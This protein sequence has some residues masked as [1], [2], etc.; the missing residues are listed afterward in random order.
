MHSEHPWWGLPGPARFI[1]SVRD[2]LRAGRNIVVALPEHHPAGLRGALAASL[3]DDD[4]LYFRV[5]DLS[6]EPAVAA[7]SPARFLHDRYAPIRDPRVD[8]SARTLAL[9]QPLRGTALWI[10]GMTDRLWPIWCKF[11]AEYQDACRMRREFERFLL[12]VP[13]VGPLTATLP[14]EE[15]ILAVHTWEGIVGRLDMMLHVGRRLER[16]RLDPL[17]HE[18][19]S[20]V[21]VEVCGSDLILADRLAGAPIEGIL[22]PLPLIRDEAAARGWTG[23]SP[24]DRNGSVNTMWACGMVDQLGGRPFP[25]SA[26]EV[27][28]GR[29]ETVRQR[30]WRG[31]VAVLFPFLE[32]RRLQFVRD[33]RHYLKVPVHTPYE[34]IVEFE[35]LELSHLCYQLRSRVSA[36]RLDP[37]ECCRHIRNELAHLRPLP[38]T[39]LLTPTFLALASSR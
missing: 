27:A 4:H 20:L 16:A 35:S 10:D 32:D 2:D 24:R 39:E 7:S 37:L 38:A 19:A 31:Q 28:A 9:A 26:A 15:L 36:R 21:L 12:I 3:R 25:H 13:L 17:F 22:D 30:V 5:L 34:T 6:E 29:P 14:N 11:L 23:A 1:E 8:P 33:F 18:L